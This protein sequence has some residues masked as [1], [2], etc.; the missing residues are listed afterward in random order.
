M[1]Q[2]DV[3][4]IGGGAMGWS[5]A[6]WLKRLDPGLSITVLE[7]APEHTR[8]G[9]A[10][11]AASIRLQFSQTLNVEISKF[12]IEFIR[13]FEKWV[14]QEIDLGFIENGYLFLAQ[15]DIQER[16]L[17]RAAA[18]QRQLGAATE[19]LDQTELQR[20][21]PWMRIED[22][23]MG[24]LGRRDE[25]WFDNMGL[26]AGLRRAAL[27]TGVSER[28][29]Q[30]TRL[31]RRSGAWCVSLEPDLWMTSRKVVLAA[32]TGTRALLGSLGE[33][34]PVERRK[35]TVFV[36]DAP[37]LRSVEAP[38]LVDPTGFWA[39]PEGGLWLTAITPIN[40][41]EVEVDDFVPDELPVRERTLAAT[42]GARARLRHFKSVAFLGRALRLQYG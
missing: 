18:M 10:L 39:R 22:I 17:R 6:F 32:G 31:Q 8:S 21:F 19:V 2:S 30:A 33:D 25:G 7:P 28:R 35:R 13:N 11:S 23:R 5:S 42:V 29:A 12:G 24:T 36:V 34:I 4:I 14:L 15:T 41:V 20:Q 16:Q 26:L 9:T 3:L 1:E 37:G 40:D 27:R 38:L